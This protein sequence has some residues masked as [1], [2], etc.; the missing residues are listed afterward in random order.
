VEARFVL[1]QTADTLK[2]PE[3]AVYRHANGFAVFR[4]DD[5]VA[6]LTPV[7]VGHRGETEVEIVAGLQRGAAI[8]VHPG[9]R[10]RDGARVEAR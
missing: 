4:V 10:V 5:G 8:A 9:D 7:T 3:G 6:R 1:W 2:V